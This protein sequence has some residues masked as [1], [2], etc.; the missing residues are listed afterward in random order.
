MGFGVEWI[1]TERTIKLERALLGEG[2]SVR[3]A[4]N[5]KPRQHHAQRRADL[6]GALNGNEG[7]RLPAPDHSVCA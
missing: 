4:A 3:W 1:D 6:G 7:S 2:R 5:N